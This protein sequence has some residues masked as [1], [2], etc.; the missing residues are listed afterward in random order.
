VR[1]SPELN[2]P[3]GQP[4]LIFCVVVVGY[5]VNVVVASLLGLMLLLAWLQPNGGVV[6]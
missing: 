4:S 6:L 2:P 3:L 1:P 5:D